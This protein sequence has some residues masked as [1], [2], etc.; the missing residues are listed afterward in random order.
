MHLKN[1]S[2]E[3]EYLILSLLILETI[4]RNAQFKVTDHMKP[5]SSAPAEEGRSIA[6]ELSWQHSAAW[7]AIYQ[8]GKNRISLPSSQTVIYATKE[9]YE[10]GLLFDHSQH[11][12]KAN[13]TS[14]GFR[15]SRKGNYRNYCTMPSY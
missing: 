15:Q 2:P 5:G 11:L 3:Q 9:E 7:T 13:A 1:V 6:Q 4:N 14:Q 12:K 8:Q 10:H